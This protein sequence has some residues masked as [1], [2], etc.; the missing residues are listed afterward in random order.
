LADGARET[1]VCR[2]GLD[3]ASETKLWIQ[4]KDILFDHAFLSKVMDDKAF[5]F[6]W[7][8]VLDQISNQLFFTTYS[9]WAEHTSSQF[10]HP[11]ILLTLALVATANHC[12]MSDYATGKRVMVMCSPDEYEGKS[13]PSMVIDCITAEATALIGYALVRCFTPPQGAHLLR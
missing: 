1:I 12:G 13:C 9:L 10:S 11:V 5:W 8:E 2:E 7:K 4:V 3:F 6:T